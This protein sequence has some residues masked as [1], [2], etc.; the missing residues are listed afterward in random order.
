MRNCAKAAVFLAKTALMLSRRCLG[1]D[2]RRNV[3]KG[4]RAMSQVC[5]NLYDGIE[6]SHYLRFL[7]EVLWRF[8][9]VHLTAPLWAKTLWSD[10]F[11]A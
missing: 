9:C 2:N 10:L 4:G 3:E 11:P 8:G 7:A 6:Q 5:D 1:L